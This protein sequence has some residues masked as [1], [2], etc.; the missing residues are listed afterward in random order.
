MNGVR[1]LRLQPHTGGAPSLIAGD[2]GNSIAGSPGASIAGGFANIIEANANFGVIGGGRAN[3]IHTDAEYATIGGGVFNTIQPK[4]YAATIGGGYGNTIQTNAERATIGGGASNTIQPYAQ[5][6]TIGGGNGNTIRTDAD[7]ATIPGGLQ[8]SATN[9]AFAAGRRAKANHTGA[10]VWADSTDAD[11]ASTVP[12]QFNVRASGGVRFSANLNVG[13]LFVLSNSVVSPKQGETLVP[14][15][16]ILTL[17]PA[18]AV[19]LHASIPIS[20]NV[21][22]GTILILKGNNDAFTVRI[23]ESTAVRL[24][25]ASRT[26]GQNDTLTM[27][28]DGA[29]WMELSF[30]NN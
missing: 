27:L 25:A 11:F 1:A 12:N 2:S 17:K 23:D 29:H 13:G 30:V 22:A 26:L 5:V 14:T 8:N 10:F 16:S 6:A 19:T 20:T 7:Y 9:Y 3:A 15:T 28:Y 24:G 4:A 21:P 18:E